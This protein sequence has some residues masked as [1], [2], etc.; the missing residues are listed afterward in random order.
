MKNVGEWLNGAICREF[1]FSM[2]SSSLLLFHVGMVFASLVGGWVIEDIRLDLT[3]R[4]K[5]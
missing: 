5:R 3:L 4:T 2:L 1:F